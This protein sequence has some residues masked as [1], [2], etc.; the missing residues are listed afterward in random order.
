MSDWTSPCFNSS[1]CEPFNGTFEVPL[2]LVTAASTRG[3]GSCNWQL[4]VDATHWIYVELVMLGNRF[5]PV[6][7]FLVFLSPHDFLAQGPNGTLTYSGVSP[8][9]NQ[10]V[11]LTQNTGNYHGAPQ[12]ITI[13]PLGS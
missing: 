12:T 2:V 9:C 10:L 11:T 13:K 8:T 6:A 4:K 7:A 1:G 5:N 3:V